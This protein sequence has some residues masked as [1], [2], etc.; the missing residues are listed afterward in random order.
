MKRH[1]L[2]PRQIQDIV[3]LDEQVGKLV[4]HGVDAVCGHTQKDRDHGPV[5]R[6]DHPPG[7]I[8]GDQRQRI[9]ADALKGR[10]VKEAEAEV[11][12][13]LGGKNQ[14]HDRH[15][16]GDQGRNKHSLDAHVKPDDG[17]HIENGGGRRRD[18]G[19][20]GILRIA[21]KTPDK[22]HQE[23]HEDA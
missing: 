13:A 9:G 11:P 12:P 21:A 1:G 19:R 15:G 7:Q 18:K 22:L 5:G 2:R 4:G 8:I 20:D 6:I 14:I 23:R 3:E 16:L 10:P 17:N